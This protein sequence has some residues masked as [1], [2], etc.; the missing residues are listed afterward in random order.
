VAISG[1]LCEL[2]LV[3]RHRDARALLAAVFDEAAGGG[4]LSPVERT[5]LERLARELAPLCAPVCG[6]VRALGAL[7][8]CDP[9]AV[10]DAY[11]DLRIDEPFAATIGVAIYG[12]LDEPV[13][14]GVPP[15]ALLDVPV[16]V[17]AEFATASLTLAQLGRLECGSVL[18]MET[19]VG[20]PAT[21]KVGDVTVAWGQCGARDGRAAF[22]T[23]GTSG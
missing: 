5:V 23:G 3:F 6:T 13:G 10:P 14:E 22:L 21:L 1:T 2:R 11:F 20:A 16:I 9:S 19:K 7:D 15:P 17:R 8:C 12:E 18:P 4:P